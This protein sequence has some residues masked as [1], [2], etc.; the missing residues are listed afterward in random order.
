MYKVA[1]DALVMG[2]PRRIA[3]TLEPLAFLG[4]ALGARNA[5]KEVAK[6]A[7]H[8]ALQVMPMW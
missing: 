2:G 6:E 7:F 5:G 8:F 3:S 1:L 4:M